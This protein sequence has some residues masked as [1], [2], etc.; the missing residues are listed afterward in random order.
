[1]E[2][3]RDIK[4]DINKKKDTREDERQEGL[5]EKSERMLM[6]EDIRKDERQIQAKTTGREE[7]Y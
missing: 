3:W 4:Q 6:K 2:G 5:D 1:M 7:G